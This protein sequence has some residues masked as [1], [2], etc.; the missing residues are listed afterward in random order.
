[1]NEAMEAFL[2]GKTEYANLVIPY[3]RNNPLMR[4]RR[5]IAFP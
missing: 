2:F 4:V 3:V 1:M 5:A